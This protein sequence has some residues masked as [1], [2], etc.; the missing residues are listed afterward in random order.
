MKAQGF[1][2]SLMFL[3]ELKTGKRKQR[4]KKKMEKVH[5]NPSNYHL[6]VNVPP[7]IINFVNLPL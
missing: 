6:I 5:I 4:K 7:Q 3:E 1:H 2:L